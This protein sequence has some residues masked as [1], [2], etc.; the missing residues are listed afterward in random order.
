MAEWTYK[1]GQKAG[2]E[3]DTLSGAKAVLLLVIGSQIVGVMGVMPYQSEVL[4][5]QEQIHMLESFANQIAMAI[6]RAMIAKEAQEVL[7]KA[8]TEELR[9]T[10]LSSVSHDLRTPLAVITGATTTSNT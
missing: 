3:T 7:L 6:D 5:D 10:L 4:F 1:H 9:S 8:E 2:L